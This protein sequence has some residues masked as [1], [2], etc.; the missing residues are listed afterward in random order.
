[1]ENVFGS[2]GWV[3]RRKA[4]ESAL[5][6]GKPSS[7]YMRVCGKHFKKEDYVCKLNSIL[8]LYF[9]MIYLLIYKKCWTMMIR[10]S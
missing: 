4:W 6:L 5:L 10:H 1:M 8:R 9:E 3:E 7:N 2:K